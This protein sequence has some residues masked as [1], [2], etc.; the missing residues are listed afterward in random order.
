MLETVGVDV[1]PALDAAWC[2]RVRRA[3]AALEWPV[4]P[5]VTRKHASG[6]Q[7]A[8]AAPVD[9]LYTATEVNE[10]ALCAAL[11]SLGRAAA[12][13]LESA[14]RHAAEVNPSPV[15]TAVGLAPV[16]AEP[17]ALARLRAFAAH[18]RNDA[19]RAL[20]AEARARDL[21]TLID[22]DSLTLG[23]G[24][25][26]ETASLAALPSPAEVPWAKVRAVP[27]G[28]V[29]GSNGKTTTVRLISAAAEAHG[30]VSGHCCTDG[31][32]VAGIE[33]GSGDYSG[34][35][36]ARRVLRDARVEAAVIETA[37]GGILRRGIAFDRADVA[38]VTNISADHFGEYGIHDLEGLAEAKL[39]VAHL[40]AERG[41]L[42]LN[43]DDPILRG[44]AATL[45]ATHGVRRIGW[46][47]LDLAVAQA[48]HAEHASTLRAAAGAAGTTQT[49]ACGVRSGRLVLAHGETE[50]DLG[51]VA[52]M[53]LTLGASARY[54]IANLAAAALGATA[55]G[56]PAATVALTFARFGA[57]AG[58]NPGRLQSFSVGGVTLLVDYAH[59]PDGLAGL[60]QVASS[61]RSRAAT[62]GRLLLLLGHAGN[63]RDEDF[64]ALA[65][66][67]AG[68]HP[69]GIVIK[70]IESYTRGRQ[71][72]EIPD[73]LRAAL[74]RRGFPAEAISNA[75]TELDGVRAALTAARP[76][77]VLVLPVHALTARA[78]TLELVATL[79]DG[80][81]TALR[82][83]PSLSP[84]I[85]GEPS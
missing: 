39:A 43:A 85:P 65:A 31:V 56:I 4:G 64:E 10:W 54:N 29:T 50:H 25:G 23:F 16:I 46:F 74:V 3:A 13:T 73:L 21:P 59:N 17:A 84:P 36:G 68:A 80:G 2:E 48:T 14:L 26:S 53:P 32:F 76:G 15:S 35:A 61:L 44:R 41:L 6:A 34:P 24:R 81:W 82:P 20:L 83:L 38:V 67:A 19:L 28:V 52:A 58:D 7:L 71:P 42:V 33:T 18:E 69:D 63:R 60:L 5:I 72:G 55:L 57:A 47:A 75:P 78:A 66:T 12:T 70:E 11:V 40:V 37:R 49:A 77:D 30:W 8:L 79:R 1:D 9:Q 51:D 62:R 22:D 27:L 45:G